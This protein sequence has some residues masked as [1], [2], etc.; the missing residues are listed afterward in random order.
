MC[1]CVCTHFLV[2][3]FQYMHDPLRDKNKRSKAKFGSDSFYFGHLV[4]SSAQGSFV[5][6]HIAMWGR[7]KD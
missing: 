4:A 5:T 7:R 1:G 3:V 2:Y 6:V